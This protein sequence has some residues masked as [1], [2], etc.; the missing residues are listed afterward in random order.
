MVDVYLKDI[1]KLLSQLDKSKNIPLHQKKMSSVHKSLKSIRDYKRIT[2]YG[3]LDS[4]R[5][6]S[7]RKKICQQHFSIVVVFIGFSCG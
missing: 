4:F 1:F 7:L 3:T 6:I 2:F 5:Q